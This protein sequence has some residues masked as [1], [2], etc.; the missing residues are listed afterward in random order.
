[1]AEKIPDC[2]EGCVKWEKFGKG[3]FVY[4]E[5]KKECTQK[6]EAWDQIPL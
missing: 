6:A 5:E 1:M 3:C 2:C 4:W